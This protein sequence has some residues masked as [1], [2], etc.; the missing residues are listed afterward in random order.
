MLELRKIQIRDI[1]ISD[2]DRIED[3]YCTLIRNHLPKL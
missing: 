3:G 2:R 1:V